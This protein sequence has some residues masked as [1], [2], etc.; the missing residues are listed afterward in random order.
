MSAASERRKRRQSC[1]GGR[2]ERMEKKDWTDTLPRVVFWFLHLVGILLAT[3]RLTLKSLFV[4]F[5]SFEALASVVAF[6]DEV[7]PDAETAGEEVT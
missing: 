7:A 1:V 6:N 2:N 3:I 4:M 5:V